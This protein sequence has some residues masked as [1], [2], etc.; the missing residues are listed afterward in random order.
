MNEEQPPLLFLVAG[1]PS[2]D[3][4][5]ARVMAALKEKTGGAIRFAGVGGPLMTAEGLASLFPMAELAVMGV[6]EVLPRL[7]NL[8]RRIRETAAAAAALGPAAVLTI[9]SPDFSFRVARKLKGRGIPLLHLVAPT[10][11]AW[12]PGRARKIARF[13]DHLLAVLPFEPP[14]FEKEGLACTFIGH[15]VVE[16]G[17]DG[18]DGK[19]FRRRHGIPPDVPL[20]C[21]LP[22]SRKSET[23][24]LLPVFAETLGL[25]RERHPGLRAVVPT[26]ETVADE[27]EAAAAR[28]P[29]PAVVLRDRAEKRD[30]FAAA[31]AALAASGTVALELALAGTPA[32]IAYRVGAISAWIGRRL[33]RV[34]FVNLVNLV[35][36]R[37]AVPEFIQ[38]DCR[39]DRLAGAVSD[40]LDDGA[41]RAR[42]IADAALALRALGLGGPSPGQRAAE[43][44]LALMKGATAGL[45]P[46][47]PR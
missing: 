20:L 27:V 19:S 32:V 25:L 37:A 34:G 36:G 1:E 38:E 44:I 14:Y 35:L 22:G 8:I 15:P 16:S 29:V 30:A 23:H 47:E 21:V 41:A 11:W 24:R 18:G 13:L 9:D 42:Q 40:L 17:L 2:G 46:R 3:A 4:L 26:V 6:A 45:P 7:F 31:A 12:R 5:G 43:V 28:W 10:V 39:A 33:I